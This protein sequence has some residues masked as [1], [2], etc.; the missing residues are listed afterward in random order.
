MNRTSA[1]LRFLPPEAGGRRRWPEGP[2]YSTLAEFEESPA[3]VTGDSWSIVAHFHGSPD[4]QGEVL[5][6]VEFLAPGAPRELLHPGA[7]FRLLEGSRTVAAGEV[8]SAQQA[9]PLDDQQQPE[10][11]EVRYARLSALIE[12]WLRTPHDDEPDYDP[13]AIERTRMK[14]A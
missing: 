1:K 5:A 2:L 8:L 14:A 12:D 10:P 6:D 4:Q 9:S 7:H 13:D 11:L 3:G